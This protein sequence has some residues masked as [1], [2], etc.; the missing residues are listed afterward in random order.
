MRGLFP[1]A[2]G[3]QVVAQS[4]TRGLSSIANSE[5][6][7]RLLDVAADRLLAE[8]ECLSDVRGLVAHRYH[9][10]DGKLARGQAR[11]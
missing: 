7:L 3:Y 1:C 5:L 11:R 9:A 4:I 6:H 8:A 10:Q 2:L